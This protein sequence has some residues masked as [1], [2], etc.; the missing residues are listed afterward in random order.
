MGFP[1]GT[2][3]QETAFQCWRHKRCYFDPW[4]GKIP[5][6]R[7]WQPTPVFLPGESHGQRS[8]VGC[9]PQG[10]TGL[11]MT[12]VTQHAAPYIPS[13]PITAV[14]WNHLPP[15][16]HIVPMLCY[17]MLSHFSHVRLCVTPQTAAHQALP[18]LVLFLFIFKSQL[19]VL[20]PCYVRYLLFLTFLAQI[21]QSSFLAAKNPD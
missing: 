3:G 4:I 19:P 6:R 8:L 18:S 17:A 9:S 21:S 2:H 5:W 20:P 14:W 7:A 16:I 10:H 13:G 15:G 1:G 11:D 12:E